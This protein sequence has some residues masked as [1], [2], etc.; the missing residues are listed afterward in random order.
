MFEYIQD[1]SNMLNE[2]SNIFFKF[3]LKQKY[4]HIQNLR[5]IEKRK[6]KR[7]RERDKK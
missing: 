7:V 2:Y 5:N 3:P 6:K 4:D 1:H